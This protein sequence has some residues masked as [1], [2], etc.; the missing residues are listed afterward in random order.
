MIFATVIV[1]GCKTARRFCFFR[2]ACGKMKGGL[3]ALRGRAPAEGV[4]RN[5]V[6][7]EGETSPLLWAQGK[8]AKPDLV[9]RDAADESA[10]RFDRVYAA[11]LSGGF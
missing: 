5:E 1:D 10:D 9:V 4:D 11:D 8:P 7:A 2:F 6:R 3:G